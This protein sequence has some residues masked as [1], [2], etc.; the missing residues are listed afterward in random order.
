MKRISTNT[1]D[2]ERSGRPN[3]AVVPENIKKVHRMVLANRKWKLREK[4]AT[5]KISEGSGIR[6]F[7]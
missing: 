4:A 5:L 1:D 3:S 6:R 7:A 2:V